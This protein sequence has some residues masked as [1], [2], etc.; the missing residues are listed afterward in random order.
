MWAARAMAAAAGYTFLGRKT[1]GVCR[2]GI[3]AMLA[4]TVIFSFMTV[5]A[6]ALVGTVGPLMSDRA[7]VLVG[8][9]LD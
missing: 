8:A 4:Q 1:A 9:P 5:L 2:P 6:K 7:R 3:L